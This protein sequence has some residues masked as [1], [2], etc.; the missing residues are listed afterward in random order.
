MHAAHE[1][2]GPFWA[3]AIVT[4]DELIASLSVERA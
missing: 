4:T 1:H 3:S 2:T